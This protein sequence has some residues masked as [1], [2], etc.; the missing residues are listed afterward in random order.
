MIPESGHQNKK[1]QAAP[2]ASGAVFPWSSE[3][4]GTEQRTLG[5]K[6][7]GKEDSGSVLFRN[8]SLTHSWVRHLLQGLH[9]T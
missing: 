9:S 8:L 2:C 3:E 5:R 1:G 7:P 6:D 4:K